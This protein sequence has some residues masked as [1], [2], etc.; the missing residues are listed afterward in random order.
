MCISHF[1][2]VSLVMTHESHTNGWM[3]TQPIPLET[4]E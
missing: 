1:S 3:V 4:G 2:I